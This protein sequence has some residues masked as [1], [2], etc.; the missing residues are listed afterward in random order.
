MLVPIPYLLLSLTAADMTRRIKTMARYLNNGLK[1]EIQ[2]PIQIL[3]MHMHMS[4]TIWDWEGWTRHD[5][6]S[7]NQGARAIIWLVEK[8]KW[9]TLVVPSVVAVSAFYILTEKHSTTDK[10]LTGLDVVLIVISAIA[11]FWQSEAPGVGD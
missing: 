9:M 6:K 8:A 11:A 5:H 10:Y 2:A 7:H 1:S 3:Q 4:A